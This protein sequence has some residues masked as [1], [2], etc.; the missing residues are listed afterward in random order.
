MAAAEEE[1]EEEE[2]R[3]S[4]SEC[5]RGCQE[6][7]NRRGMCPKGQSREKTPTAKSRIIHKQRIGA[8]K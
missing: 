4:H 8:T 2:E 1:E 3:V 6:A 5:A 7:E